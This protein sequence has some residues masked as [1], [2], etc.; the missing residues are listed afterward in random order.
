MEV[1]MV[2]TD[3]AATDSPTAGEGNPVV[4]IDSRVAR[5]FECAE[6]RRRDANAAKA[7]VSM[8]LGHLVA[9]TSEVHAL[10]AAALRDLYD[11]GGFSA[12]RLPDAL[13]L[14]RTF[15][16]LGRQMLETERASRQ[17]SLDPNIA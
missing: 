14:I 17:L 4:R 11:A 13:P 5:R 15:E 12:E 9:E 3:A 1:K 10:M 7:P 6:V 16:R 8:L 2:T